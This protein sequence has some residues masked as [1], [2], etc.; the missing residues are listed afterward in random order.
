MKMAICSVHTMDGPLMVVDLVLRSL[1]H[2][3]KARNLGLISRLERV[4]QGSLL[5]CLKA[6]F[7]F[8]QM[9]MVGKEPMPPH[10]QGIQFGICSS[11]CVY[12]LISSFYN[13]NV[14]P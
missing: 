8:G 3:Q 13:D 11:F 9:R 2:Q 14:S 10:L 1:R 6:F 7:S 4:L 5:W 12:V